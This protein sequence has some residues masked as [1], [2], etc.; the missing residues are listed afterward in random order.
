MIA[1]RI[2]V[3]TERSGTKIV[4][5]FDKL[6]CLLGSIRIQCLVFLAQNLPYS[7]ELDVEACVEQ[8]ILDGHDLPTVGAEAVAHVLE[9]LRSRRSAG[10]VLKKVLD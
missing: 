1:Y 4:R 5:T 10:F 8:W 6:R 2:G 3:V 7:H 9:R